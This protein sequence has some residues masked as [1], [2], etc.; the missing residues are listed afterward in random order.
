MTLALNKFTVLHKQTMWNIKS[1]EQ[2]KVIA[3]TSKVQ[4]LSDA[5]LKLSKYLEE[6]KSKQNN[7]KVK[8]KQSEKDDKWAWAKKAPKP[9]K[10]WMKKF[11]KKTYNWC[12]W[13]KTWVI[14]DPNAT[15]G[16]NVCKIRLAEESGTNPSL[17]N[18][19]QETTNTREEGQVHVT[20]ALVANL[21]HS[22]PFNRN[23][24]TC[25]VLGG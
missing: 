3:L 17:Q 20:Q 13:H 18:S 8:K 5:N 25:I 1:P 10:P 22:H 7:S 14:H 12:K 6:K 23:E 21:V 9:G 11:D 2:V 4:K 16:P 24:P 19:E 15:S